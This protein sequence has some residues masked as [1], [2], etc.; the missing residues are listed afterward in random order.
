MEPWIDWV[1][2]LQ[3][4]SETGLAYATDPYDIARYEEVARLAQEVAGQ[5]TGLDTHGA[6]HPTPK[7]DVRGALIRDDRVLLV[8]EKADGGWTLPGGWADLGEPPSRSA[9][10]EFREEAGIPVRATKLIAVHDRDRHNSPPHAHHIFKLFFLVEETGEPHGEPDHEVSAVDWFALDDLPPL[11]TG[12]TSR[13]QLELAFA[14][15]A[16]PERPAD[17]D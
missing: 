14:H 10:R 4:V 15:A 16:R 9:E 3:H 13:D 7:V 11:S 12:R 1:R 8:R 6:G 17:F 2:R 5:G